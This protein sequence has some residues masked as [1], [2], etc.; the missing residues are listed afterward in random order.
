MWNTWQKKGIELL[1]NQ[2]LLEKMSHQARIRGV[3]K[4][5]VDVKIPEYEKL[6]QKILKEKIRSDNLNE[7]TQ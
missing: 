2:Q 7:R 3:E 6:Y 1:E 5:D 4:F